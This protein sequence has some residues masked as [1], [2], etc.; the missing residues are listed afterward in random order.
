YYCAIHNGEKNICSFHKS[1]DL[2][3]TW[4]IITDGWYESEN[5]ARKNSGARLAVTDADPE[6]VYAVLIGDSKPGDNGYIGIYR[7][8]D[9]GES[10]ML[11]NPPAG[12]P[13]NVETHPCLTT[14]NPNA[15]NPYN[16]GFYNLGFAVSDSDP[17]LIYAG[18]LNTFKSADGGKTFEWLGGYG[19]TLK[20]IHPDCQEI[21]IN[22]DDFWLATDGGVNYSD[23]FPTDH[24]SRTNGI[25][26]SDYWGFDVG[27]NEDV[28][29]GGRYH[30]GN[31]AYCP[32]FPE[33]VQQSLGGGEAPT[34]Y[35]NPL[36]NKKAYFSD[37]GGK[38]LP[39]S[40]HGAVRSFSQGLYPTESYWRASSSE[41]EFDPRHANIIYLGRED[42]L[43]K[44]D[45]GGISYVALN[46][47]TG[48]VSSKVLHIEISR[49]N[50]DVI[51]CSQTVSGAIWKT[52]DA[53]K[54]WNQTTILPYK[55][56]NILLAMS[57]EDENILWAAAHTSNA[58]NKIF[59]T[60]DGGE[61]WEN[62]TTEIFGA[63]RPIS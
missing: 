50:P 14:F 8:N 61:T 9:A 51:Y 62:L 40:L 43:W 37:I 63:E 47:F 26:A 57:A 39:D 20:N 6:V 35:L 45:D 24:D 28:L 49:S 48:G 42:K 18:F 30:N 36:N 3:L 27:W 34:G 53:G 11:P 5:S 25:T 31:S 29:V 46:T 55:T 16:Q 23:I 59:K 58:E 10:W 41:M 33:G 2:G 7:S 56:S 44:S 38:Y 12:G 60:T 32:A 52:T 1:T 13:Y 15:S 4:S 22:G 21:E 54:T 17:N 19:G